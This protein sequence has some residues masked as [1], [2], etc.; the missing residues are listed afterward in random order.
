MSDVLFVLL[1]SFKFLIE[2]INLYIFFIKVLFSLVKAGHCQTILPYNLIQQT[3]DT[4]LDAMKEV[5]LNMLL[6]V[7]QHL[8]LND[9]FTLMEHN[10]PIV[11]AFTSSAWATNKVVF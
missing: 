3:S 6:G 8:P 10:L 11:M 7:A 4:V 2:I 1:L 9:C 5:T